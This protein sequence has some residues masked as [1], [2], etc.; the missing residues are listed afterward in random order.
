MS[1]MADD[2]IEINKRRKE[3]RKDVG[4]GDDDW[5]TA[6]GPDLD[7]CAAGYGV[8]RIDNEYDDAMRTR[9]QAV[10]DRMKWSKIGAGL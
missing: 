2:F 10:V 9:I 6:G 4:I 7:R 1:R 3:I 5:R 8:Y